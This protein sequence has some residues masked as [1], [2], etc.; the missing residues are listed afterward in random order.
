ML[1]ERNE[2]W[3]QRSS[4]HPLIERC[5]M[6]CV[7]LINT[8][9]IIY[10]YVMEII[11]RFCCKCKS[12]DSLPF[13]SIIA[14]VCANSQKN[15]YGNCVYVRWWRRKIMLIIP[16]K[17]KIIGLIEHSKHFCTFCLYLWP[18]KQHTHTN[19]PISLLATSTKQIWNQQKTT[20]VESS[21]YILLISHVVIMYK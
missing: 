4:D 6:Y 15:W 12:Y 2:H 20:H 10:L 14:I 9:F 21:L 19:V 7:Q 16:I 5:T 18:K 11:S 8:S 13:H 17:M 3:S 1:P